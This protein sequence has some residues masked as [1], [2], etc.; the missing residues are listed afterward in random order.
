MSLAAAECER[1]GIA[2]VVIQLLRVAAER[3]RPPRAL[4]VPFPHGYPLDRPNDPERQRAVLAAALRLLE[5]PALEPP[6]L[7]D[8]A[9]GPRIS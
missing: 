2:T 6:V 8:F 3:V 7:A 4:C 1:R 9:P 5:D